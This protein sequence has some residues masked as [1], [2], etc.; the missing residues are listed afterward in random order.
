[1]D[2]FIKLNPIQPRS[3]RY[4]THYRVYLI[5]LS[6]I[7]AFIASFW[8]YQFTQ[9]PVR[10]LWDEYPVEL[11]LSSV[12]IIGFVA[13]YFFWLRTKFNQNVQ[14]FED[15]LVLSKGR[16]QLT[17]EFSHIESVN[18]IGWSLFY[19]KTK[20]GFKHYFSASLERVDYI[21]EGLNSA[22]PDLFDP[23]AFEE[24][25]LNLVQY[26]HHQ[27]RKEWFFKHKMIDLFNWMCLPVI[28]LGVA[29]IAQSQNILIHQ[30]GLYFFRLFMYSLLV[31]LTTAF[32]Y[33]LILKKLIFDRKISKQLESKPGDKLRDI[34]FEGIVLHRSKLLQLVTA[35]FL[36]TLIVKTDLNLYSVTKMK[37]EV[38]YFE[39][40]AGKTLVI[41]NRY[42]CIHCKFK[43]VDGDMV[44]FGRGAV[45]QILASEGELVGEVLQDKSGRMIASENVQEVPKGH[46][47]MKAA[48]GKDII[49]VKIDEVIGK[50]QK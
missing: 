38:A 13:S 45:G 6:I 39:L 11:T 2:Q 10:A 15:R 12:Y 27:K 18:V 3:L 5:F 49:F 47:A 4:R 21:W 42:N 50:I 28:F 44:V 37:G 48:N 33:S 29:Y 26:D 7:L 32:L 35:C 19:V 9:M 20:D 14:V 24:F 17:L 25:R 30:K 22:R 40:Q 46:V 1:L 8:G 43:L 41:D 36:M 23:R 31:L 16:K 34:E